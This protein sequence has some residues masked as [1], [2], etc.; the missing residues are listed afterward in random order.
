MNADGLL[1]PFR[2]SCD[3]LLS[4]LEPDDWHTSSF[5]EHWAQVGIFVG[6]KE[7]FAELANRLPARPDPRGALKLVGSS[8]VR[9]SA[10]IS[11]KYAVLSEPNFGLRPRELR[12]DN[13]EQQLVSTFRTIAVGRSDDAIA[14][15]RPFLA[16]SDWVEV[17]DPFFGSESAE[18]ARQRLSDAIR[19]TNGKLVVSVVAKRARN[20]KAPGD[21]P[22]SD[23]ELRN[24]IQADMRCQLGQV[25]AVAPYPGPVSDSSPYWSFHDRFFAFGTNESDVPLRVV[26]VG[27]GH[28]SLAGKPTTLSSVH[29]LHYSDVIRRRVIPHGRP[30]T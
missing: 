26:G 24:R 19:D 1:V 13:W 16:I 3:T 11:R 23:A 14:A 27:A 15:L 21:L 9:G 17:F 8:C 12:K 30:R 29:P 4:I 10:G 5:L 7:I 28:V 2:A 6:G 20:P 22:R 25:R 18:A